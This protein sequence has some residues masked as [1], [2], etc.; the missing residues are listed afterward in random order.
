MLWLGAGLAAAA[1]ARFAIA[2]TFK[3]DRFVDAAGCFFECQRD[4]DLKVVASARPCTSAK[5]VAES[6]TASAAKHFT[7]RRKDVFGRTKLAAATAFEARMAVAIVTRTFVVV[8]EHFVRFSRCF[9]FRAGLLVTRIT[10]RMIFDRQ[11]AISFGD[12]PARS[13]LGDAEQFVVAGFFHRDFP[14]CSTLRNKPPVWR[15]AY[16]RFLYASKD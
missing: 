6:A 10:V 1:V 11:L 4:L 2:G 3:I 12:L 16:V 9:E 15:V 8:A 13:I 7:K 14:V 5:D